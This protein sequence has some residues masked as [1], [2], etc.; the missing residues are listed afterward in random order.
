ME[1]VGHRIRE[2]RNERNWSQERLANEADISANYLSEVE[3]GARQGVSMET[4]RKIADG[5]DV[6]LWQ[7]LLDNEISEI[8]D[9]IILLLADRPRDIQET[10]LELIE[11]HL[12]GIDRLQSKK[13][14]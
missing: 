12:K 5:L 1:R 2:L 4:Y 14:S 13:E 9:S 3:N 8:L 10:A 7:L 11:V 6:P